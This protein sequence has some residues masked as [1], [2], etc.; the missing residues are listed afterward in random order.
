M[1]ISAELFLNSYP[2]GVL[3]DTRSPAEYEKGHLPGA[4]CFPLFE[5]DERAEIGTLYKR[6]G[7]DVAVMRGLEIIGPKMAR[8][9]QS[10]AELANGQTVYLYCWRGG[11][12]SHSMG[13]LLETA[14]MNVQVLEGGY[15]AFR[16]EVQGK[17]ASDYPLLVL[18]GY[19]GSAKT[20][21]LQLMKKAG[22]QVIDLEALAQHKGS[23]F[24]NLEDE[25]QPH[26]EHFANLVWSELRSFNPDRPVWV[27]DESRSI[28]TVYLDDGLYQKMHSAPL[29]MLE[30][31]RTERAAFL[32][33]DYGAINPELLIYG[34]EKITKRLGG[35]HAKAAIAHIQEGELTEAAKIL[36]TYYDKAYQHNMNR[37]GDALLHRVPVADGSSNFDLAVELIKNEN[38]WIPSV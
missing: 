1:T 10:A 5:N 32:A 34:V 37:R 25:P 20:Q 21:I 22:A 29:V 3:L 36:L 31:S 2:K 33:E 8:M 35:Q 13:W 18:G 6:K 19:T 4:L 28:G 12:R 17:L 30:R 14:G 23:A 15:K 11:M 9:A 16:R 38:K 26:T 7:R 24:G 27:E